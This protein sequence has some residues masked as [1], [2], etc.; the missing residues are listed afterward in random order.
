MSFEDKMLQ[1]PERIEARPA[2]VCIGSHNLKIH[3]SNFHLAD[4]T[5][6]HP[7]VQSIGVPS[8]QFQMNC[9]KLQQQK[10][11]STIVKKFHYCLQNITIKILFFSLMVKIVI[12]CT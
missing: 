12:A 8:T 4:E 3:I 1:L 5:T 6:L 10:A 9:I 2:V 11:I 7:F